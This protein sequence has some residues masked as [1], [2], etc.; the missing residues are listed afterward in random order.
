VIRDCGSVLITLHVAAIQ[1]AG[2][3]GYRMPIPHCALR[4]RPLAL[5][6]RHPASGGDEPQ[7]DAHR[8]AAASH[9]PVPTGR[10]VW[11]S[12][13]KT[14]YLLRALAEKGL[15][16]ASN[17]RNSHNKLAYSYLLTPQGMVHKAASRALTWSARR[18][19]TKRSRAGLSGLRLTLTPQ[20][21]L[22]R[23]ACQPFATIKS[24]LTLRARRLCT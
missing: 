7:G 4:R 16:K 17:F 13:G 2:I 19:S 20:P 6:S 5:P 24:L 14:N 23:R 22:A 3:P 8:V 12:L 21:C 18:P 1:L 10:A 9:E 11:V 15:L